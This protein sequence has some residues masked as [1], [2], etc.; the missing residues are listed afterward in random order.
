MDRLC[1]I[2]KI[3]S[4]RLNT[5]ASKGGNKF[6]SITQNLRSMATISRQ[7]RHRQIADENSKFF[8][9]LIN[10]SPTLSRK[11][12]IKGIHSNNQYK[13][14]MSRSKCKYAVTQILSPTTPTR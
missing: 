5:S 10:T 3:S 11:S 2:E 4:S 12:W 7:N 6:I 1:N 8:N 9:R 13:L 14:N